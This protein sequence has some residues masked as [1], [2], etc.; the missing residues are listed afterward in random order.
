[1]NNVPLLVNHNVAIVTV[2]DLQEKAHDTVGGHTFDKLGTSSLVL[3]RR[4][5]SISLYEV[6]VQ[7]SVRL[8]AQLIS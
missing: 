7:R 1:M 8:S 4:L 3:T 6:I 2:F 5:L